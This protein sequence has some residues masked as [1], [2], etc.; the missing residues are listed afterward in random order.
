MSLT[1]EEQIGFPPN[2]GRTQD[3]TF[4]REHP[5]AHAVVR[6][7][8]Q[9]KGIPYKAAKSA[10]PNSLASAYVNHRYLVSW[11][12][13]INPQWALL[14]GDDDAYNGTNSSEDF[15]IY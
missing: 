4:I 11:R 15:Q 14:S 8:L 13:R 10:L 5:L 6:S 2:S 9:T 3:E 12:N 1:L 7:W